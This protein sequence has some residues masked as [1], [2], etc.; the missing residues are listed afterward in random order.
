MSGQTFRTRWIITLFVTT[1]FC[2]FS[3]TIQSQEYLQLEIKNSLKNIRFAPSQKLVYKTKDFPKDWQKRKIDYFIYENDLIVFNNGVEN[4]KNIT[5]IRV[6]QPLPF[7]VSKALYLFSLR[8]LVFGGIDIIYRGRSLQGKDLVY[9]V[10]PAGLAFFLDKF[11]SFKRYK[12]GKNTNLRLLDLRF[13]EEP[14][15]IVE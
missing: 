13:L 7:Y 5:E 2:A 8:S 9:T 11:V 4:V 6:F 15:V 3:H 14:D 12:I 1:I 10:V